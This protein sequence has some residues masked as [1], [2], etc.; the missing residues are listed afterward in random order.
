VPVQP[1]ESLPTNA[2]QDA[3]PQKSAN[4]TYLDC[5]KNAVGYTAAA[6]L[7]G[8]GAAAGVGSTAALSAVGFTSGG[9]AAGTIAAGAQSAIVAVEAGSIFAYLQS[10]G[11]LATG[12]FGAAFWPVTIGVGAVAGSGYIYSQCGLPVDI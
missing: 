9:V 5:V 10:A 12:V 1:Q 11:A 2:S 7:V 3:E 6:S 8:G 4:E